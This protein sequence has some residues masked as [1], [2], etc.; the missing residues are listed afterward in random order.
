MGYKREG[1]LF[2]TMINKIIPPA[3]AVVAKCEYDSDPQSMKG[4]KYAVTYRPSRLITID[5]IWD[6][7]VS[8]ADGE[9]LKDLSLSCA[10]FQRLVRQHYFGEVCPETSHIKDHD[11]VFN[12]LLPSEGDFKRAFRIVEVELGFCYD[13]FFTKYYY[14]FALL[15][16]SQPGIQYF[17]LLKIILILTVGVFA[18]RKSLVLETPNPIIEVHTSGADYW[19]TLLVLF[20]ALIVEIVQAAVYLA[21]NW[22]QVSVAC[23]HVKK[24]IYFWEGHWFS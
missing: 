15:N 14:T 13:F 8:S 6:S 22:A 19:I 11:F 1:S 12:K 9:A 20:V 3:Q 23:L 7:C 21:S 18:V 2:L 5:Q 16:S 10:L 4:Y 24:C 17:A